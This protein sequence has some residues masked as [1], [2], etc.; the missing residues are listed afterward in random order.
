MMEGV[1]F[2]GCLHTALKLMYLMDCFLCVCAY[3]KERTYSCLSKFLSASVSN[4]VLKWAP[5]YHFVLAVSF[6]FL[7]KKKIIISPVPGLG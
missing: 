6:F 7:E 3:S 4:K 5:L 2:L 1:I